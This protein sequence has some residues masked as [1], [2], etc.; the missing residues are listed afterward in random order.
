MDSILCQEDEVRK[1]QVN[2]ETMAAVFF[3]VEKAYDILWREGLLIKMHLMGIK[4]KL[5]N[6]LREFL[7]KRTI[8][9]KVGTE[10]SRKWDTTSVAEGSLT[11]WA[12]AHLI[13]G[14]QS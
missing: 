6:W 10:R 1:A 5:F 2:K 13:W 11:L 12:S 4:G 14:S 3:Y 8:Q 9:V 7:D